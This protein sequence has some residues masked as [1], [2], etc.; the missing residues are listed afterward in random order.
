MENWGLITYREARLLFDQKKT[1]QSTEQ[2]IVEVIAHELANM[3]FGNI[4][5]PKWYVYNIL[6]NIDNDHYNWLLSYV[7]ED[8]F[9]RVE[10]I[11]KT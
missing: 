6:K 8:L 3:W 2:S 1:S 4:V 11:K 7:K 5:S 9:L 10:L